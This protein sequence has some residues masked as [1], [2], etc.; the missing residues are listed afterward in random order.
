MTAIHI[1]DLETIALVEMLAETLGSNK[2]AAI[3]LA[4]SEALE[5]RGQSITVEM[6]QYQGGLTDTLMARLRRE[7]V[8]YVRLREQATSRK[9]GSR[10]YGM[11]RR[12]GP[13]D[14]LR[15]LIMAGPTEGLRFL[16][17]QD[18]LDLAAENAAI[19]PAYESLIPADVRERAR[20]NLDY[21]RQIAQRRRQ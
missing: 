15:R 5:R 7:T 10:I 21:A 18:R 11:L 6:P 17:E 19:D 2:T 13:V 16:I 9:S 3:R 12:H 1:A 14:T 4:T 20:E 8:E